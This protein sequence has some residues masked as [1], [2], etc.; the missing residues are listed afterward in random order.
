VHICLCVFLS[1][2][3]SVCLSVY[4][5]LFLCVC[6]CV[7]VCVCGCV[8]VCVYVCL[9]VCV[10]LSVCLPV[11]LHNFLTPHTRQDDSS[12]VTSRDLD[13]YSTVQRRHVMHCC[14]VS[15]PK[16]HATVMFFKGP[17]TTLLSRD[18]FKL[19]LASFPA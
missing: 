5:S 16:Q 11:A 18:S 8:F 9:Y 14:F 12:R 10:C 13:Y 7:C 4:L 15:F 3:L 1:V 6:V 19:S 17:A 2:C